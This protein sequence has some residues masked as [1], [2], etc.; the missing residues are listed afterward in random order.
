MAVVE[1]KCPNCGGAMGLANNQFMCPN[2]RTMLLNIMDAKIDADVTVMSPDEFAKKIEES[3]RQF[4]VN[5]N[6]NLQVFDVET[7]IINKRIED[8]SA[9][10][11]NGDFEQ[12]EK[13]LSGVP[14]TIL[15]AERLR[16]LAQFKAKNEYEL[17]YHDGYIDYAGTNDFGV[18]YPPRHYKNIIELADEQTKA[19]Y[20][21]I[22]AYCREQFDT[23][24][25]INQEIKKV[26]GL[27]NV[28][29]YADAVAYAKE[30]CRK[31]PQTVFSWDYLCTV[32]C[33]IDN[34]YYCD[35]EYTMM[36]KCVDYTEGKLPSC[37]EKKAQRAL[38]ISSEHYQG[39]KK[40]AIASFCT[41]VCAVVGGAI[42][43][44][45]DGLNILFDF[46]RGQIPLALFLSLGV[47]G[48][49]IF[50]LI[51]L[52][53]LG[54]FV[55]DSV[56][57]KATRCLPHEEKKRLNNCTLPTHLKMLA[58]IA[59][60]LIALGFYWMINSFMSLV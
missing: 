4:I 45:F 32:K 39:K 24:Q 9:L 49:V 28:K 60:F 23:K 52:F 59:P 26:E 43:Q 54:D 10:L 17:S 7:K 35:A 16:F 12:V 58:A 48:S 31:H 21:K 8:A 2:C 42:L 55:S 11:E 22:A 37:I 19:T 44:F 47:I 6:D 13:A 33:I 27:L 50:L 38:E 56:V 46:E 40:F 3:K 41:G 1:M 5:I 36:Q 53:N 18:D 14:E 57:K 34:N 20:I 25:K 51:S 29:L 30:M 15:S